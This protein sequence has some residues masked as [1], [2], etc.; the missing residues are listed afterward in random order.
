MRVLGVDPGTKA[1]G[2]AVVEGGKVLAS[3]Q[4][5][6]GASNEPISVRLLRLAEAVE[7]YINTYT[8]DCV[9]IEDGYVSYSH[10][11]G[12]NKERINPKTSLAIGRARGAVELTAGKH[13]LSVAY[14]QP[15]TVKR[16]FTGDGKAD[17]QYMCRIAQAMPR[18]DGGKVA[19]GGSNE[20]EADAIG[21]AYT[22]W[23]QTKAV[24]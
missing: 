7:D 20:D 19:F 18:G 1:A 24:V 16:I 15:S 8:P 5:K 21:I 11:K 3:R 9:A 17:K 13:G 6:L 4:C 23:A 12:A 2:V 10:G 22:H 14:Y